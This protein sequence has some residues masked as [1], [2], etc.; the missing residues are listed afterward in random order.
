[1][2]ANQ[3]L[4]QFM[5][6]VNRSTDAEIAAAEREAMEASEEILR[7][8]QEQCS[9]EAAREIAEKKAKITAKYQKRMSQVG[10]RG[11]TALLSRRQMLLMQLFQDLR[12]KLAEFTASAEYAPWL[13]GLLKKQKPEEHSV[14]LLREADMPLSEQLRKLLPDSCTFRIDPSIRIGGLSVLSADG[15]RC[16]NHTLDEAYAAKFRN[17]YRDHKIDGGDE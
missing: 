4:T 6:S 14:I 17:F 1:M 8:A 11:R 16:E 15:R 2:D 5:D 12:G 13:M 10:Y 7:T 3:K 9:A